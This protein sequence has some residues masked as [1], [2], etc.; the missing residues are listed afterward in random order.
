MATVR[1]LIKGS[2][3]LLG[4]IAPG[5]TPPADEQAE[6]LLALNGLI[7]SW[8]TESLTIFSRVREVFA[9]T[10]GQQMRTL[11]VGGNF[12]T[13]RPMEIEQAGLLAGGVEMPVRILTFA[14]WSAI[15]MKDTPSEIPYMIYVEWEFPL[16]K[17]YIYPVPS[18]ANSL[19]LY[20]RKPLTAFDSVNDTLSLPEGYERALRYNLAIELAPEY[21]KEPTPKTEYIAIEAKANIK[22]AN[23][24]P[25]LMAADEPFRRRRWNI[26]TGGYDP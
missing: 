6:A 15:S 3:R 4:A 25:I 12:N 2:L 24:K 10:P 11:G 26:I 21:G 17:V 9:L 16:A 7:S 5:E 8:S 23:M 22:R 18:V 19:V 20:S 14:E 13:V 1:D